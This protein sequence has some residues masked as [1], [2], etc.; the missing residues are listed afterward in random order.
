MVLV[1]AVVIVVGAGLRVVS[2]FSSYRTSMT[3]GTSTGFMEQSPRVTAKSS[4]GEVATG[5]LAL[6][7][8]LNLIEELTPK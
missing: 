6:L 1:V 4:R 5:T 3:I 8:W 7:G 2:V